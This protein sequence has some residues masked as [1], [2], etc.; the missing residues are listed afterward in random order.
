[1]ERRQGKIII[2]TSGG[3]ASKN[4]KTYKISLPSSWVNEMMG[5]GSREVELSFDGNSIIISASIQPSEY[6]ERKLRMNHQVYK[7]SYYDADKLC[8]LIYADF[9]DKTVKHENYTDNI[10]KTA[11]GTNKLP[12]WDD[13]QY[14]LKERCISADRAGL[15]EY[16]G[17]I[18]L[19]E[20]EPFE[21][22]KRTQGRMAEDKQWLTIEKM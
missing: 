15:R 21:I 8:T 6:A 2:G 17:T 1:M 13:F 7:I 12:T 3:T 11:F 4:S 10:I 5:D 14:F 18:G 22:V 16:L 20:Y 19:Y 9:T